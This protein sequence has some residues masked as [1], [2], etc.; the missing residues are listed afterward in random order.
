MNDFRVFRIVQAGGKRRAG[1]M[2]HREA[3]ASGRTRS[4]P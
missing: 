2:G 3:R 1:G 4:G